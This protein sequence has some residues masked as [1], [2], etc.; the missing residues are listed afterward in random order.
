MNA[1]EHVSLDKWQL[2][3]QQQQKFWPEDFWMT[4]ASTSVLK[5]KR[6]L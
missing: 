5:S 3:Q 6:R 4:A 1:L 2:E